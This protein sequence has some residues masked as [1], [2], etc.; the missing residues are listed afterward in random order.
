MLREL[1]AARAR[2]T[3]RPPEPLKRENPRQVLGFGAADRLTIEIV[4]K[5]QR[6]FAKIVHPDRGGSTEAM[7]RINCAAAELIKELS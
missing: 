3:R 7:Q 4:K 2:Q 1:E 5:R 6:E